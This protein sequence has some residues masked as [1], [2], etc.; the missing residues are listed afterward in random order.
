MASVLDTVTQR[1]SS[2]RLEDKPVI[3]FVNNATAIAQLVDF[4]DGPPAVPPSI[5]IDLEGVNLSRHGTISSMQVY[6]LPTNQPFLTSSESL[7]GSQ[8]HCGLDGEQRA[9]P[10]QDQPLDQILGEYDI[11][12]RHRSCTD[13][14]M[15]LADEMPRLPEAQKEDAKPVELRLGSNEF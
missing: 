12:Y 5:F 15:R 14:V 7:H 6:Y 11:E 8:R 1:L 13:K 4:L 10:R 9:S 3:I 2:V